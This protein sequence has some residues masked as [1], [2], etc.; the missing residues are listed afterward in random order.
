MV[1]GDEGEDTWPT[2]R[3]RLGS[4]ILEELAISG[5]VLSA[6]RFSSRASVMPN[7]LSNIGGLDIIGVSRGVRWLCGILYG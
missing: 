2:G 1:N 6:Q 3:N 7:I 4:P 5:L